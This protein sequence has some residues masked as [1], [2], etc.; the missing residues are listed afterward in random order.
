MSPRRNVAATAGVPYSKGSGLYNALGPDV[1]A[2][3]FR[4]SVS[5]DGVGGRFLGASFTGAGNSLPRR[6]ILL[7]PPL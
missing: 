6:L 1:P 7:A 2:L 3:S 4:P 5:P